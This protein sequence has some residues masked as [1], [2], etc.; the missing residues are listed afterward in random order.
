MA[1]EIV[2]AGGRSLGERL[3]SVRPMGGGC[4]G[5]VYRVE[6]EDGTPLVA[7]VD[8]GGESHLEREAYMLGYLRENS[9]LPVPEVYHGSEMLLLME[10][11]EGSSDFSAG[12]E[13]HAA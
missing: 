4:I 12:A 2:A 5:E 7:K 10:F 11:I 8:T 13:R 1:E 6:L 9:D 3:K